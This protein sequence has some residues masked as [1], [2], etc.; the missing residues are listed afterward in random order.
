MKKLKS[1]SGET[2]VETLASIFV[3]AIAAAI[4]AAM[5]ASAVRISSTA[6]ART[7][8]LYADLSVAEQGGGTDPASAVIEYDGKSIPVDILQTGKDNFFTSYRREATGP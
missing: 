8:E 3:I 4:L 1:S 2:M 6:D 5:I 7:E